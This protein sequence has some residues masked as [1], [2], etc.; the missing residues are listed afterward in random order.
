M[1]L[2]NSLDIIMVHLPSFIILWQPCLSEYRS[3]TL[4]SDRCVVQ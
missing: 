2:L 4:G 3:R 1:T